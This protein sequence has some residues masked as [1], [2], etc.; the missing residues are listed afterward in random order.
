MSSGERHVRHCVYEIIL[1]ENIIFTTEIL[2]IDLLLIWKIKTIK[3]I[4]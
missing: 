4:T 2:L 1:H 3:E